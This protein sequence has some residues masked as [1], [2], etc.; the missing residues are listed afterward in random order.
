MAD[1]NQD[2]NDIS[3]RIQTRRRR[4]TQMNLLFLFL[5]LGIMGAALIYGFQKS[6]K[7]QEL[8]VELTNTSEE[9]ENLASAQNTSV[10]TDSLKSD[11]QESLSTDVIPRLIEESLSSIDPAHSNNPPPPPTPDSVIVKQVISQLGEDG[12]IGE[13]SLARLIVIQDSL[14]TAE[15]ENRQRIREYELELARLRTLVEEQQVKI[16]SLDIATLNQDQ[17]PPLPLSSTR[18]LSERSGVAFPEL[19]LLMTVGRFSSGR[20]NKVNIYSLDNEEQIFSEN[21]SLDTDVSFEYPEGD[22]C[23]HVLRIRRITR[24]PLF[25][26]QMQVVIRTNC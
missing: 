13:K 22:A 23:T 14:M 17:R 7:L 21:I 8:D 5:F 1:E 2:L 26:D 18:I 25:K 24:I 16:Q 15:T 12:F 11:I 10:N 19:D 9:V 3:N 20:I 6:S 4:F